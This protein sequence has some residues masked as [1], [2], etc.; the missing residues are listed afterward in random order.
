M[1]AFAYLRVSGVG[2]VDGD[3]FPRQRDAI[4]RYCDAHEITLVEE[5]AENGVSGTKDIS[6]RPALQRLY[7]ALEESK[8]KTVI[9][10]KLDR[11]ARDLMVQE[12]MIS[13][14]RKHGITLISVA[15]PDLCSEDPGRILVRQIFGAVAQY[16][17]SVLV[18]RMKAARDRMRKERGRC[19]G[20]KPFGNN[21]PEKATREV[22]H[23][24]RREGHT[25]QTIATMLNHRGC[26]TRGGKPWKTG[27][28]AK[29]LSREA[30]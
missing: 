17:R 25:Y 30:A 15:E 4:H 11:L 8:V 22:M 5:F 28:V 18:L 10:E 13:D 29:I 16:E 20:V 12:T 21:D 24:L 6:L 3:G 14:F 9:I 2:Q 19:E 23:L 7:L 27:T 1:N 26:P